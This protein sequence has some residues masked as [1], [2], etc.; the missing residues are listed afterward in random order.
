MFRKIKTKLRQ[1]SIPAG[2]LIAYSF[3][4]IIL[5]GSILLTLPF[6]NKITPTSYI[7]NLFVATSA[8]CVTGLSPIV[9]REQYNVLGQ[10]ILIVLVQIGGLGFMTFLFLFLNIVRSKIT[11]RNRALFQEALSQDNLALLPRL[12]RTIFIYTFGMELLGA[13]LFSLVFVPEFG[14]IRGIYYGFWHAVSGFCNAGFD[15]LG[16]T[17][18]IKYQL[19]PAINFIV[20]MLIIT[21]GIGF[22]VVLD[23]YDKWQNESHKK[24]YFSFSRYCHSL[25]LHTKV[26]LITTLILLVSGTL[27]FLT[28]EFS[29]PATIGTFDPGQKLMVSFFQST[30]TRT[31][32][33]AT[34]DMASMNRVTKMMM[35]VYML[36]GGSPAS[37]AGGIKTVTFAMM[38]IMIYCV[39]NGK[40]EVVIFN[41]RIKKRIMNQALSIVSIS[42]AICIVA[43]MMLLTI[44]PHIEVLDL[45]ME[46]F[47]AFGTVGLSCSVTPQLCSLSKLIVIVLMYTGRIGP[48][49]MMFLFSTRNAR[50]Q[51]EIKYPDEDVL[52][53]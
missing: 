33:F 35:C 30:T 23:L 52:I 43:L 3:L 4:V 1:Q 44:E 32:G 49:S 24:T 15:L 2:K 37:T 20:C 29:N 28:M 10:L 36:I 27:L 19:N 51:S 47:S 11:L 45:A 39:I 48:I 21:G 7:N 25:M 14:L 46:V 22:R 5:I 9:V 8:V 18:L 53:G 6:T 41:R 13:L 31:A 40:S 42:I 12:L 50:R 34:V 16:S 26:V 17:S 38:V